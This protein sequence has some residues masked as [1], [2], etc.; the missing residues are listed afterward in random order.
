MS[1]ELIAVLKQEALVTE[2]RARG[3]RLAYERES[4]DMAVD[5]LFEEKGILSGATV[6]AHF[7]TGD[8]TYKYRGLEWDGPADM[9]V[10]VGQ[11]VLKS[12]ALSAAGEEVICTFSERRIV[13]KVMK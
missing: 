10:L 6:V 3:A 4:L 13:E 1:F 7:A 12:G 8:V 11:K 2:A 5:T 9:P